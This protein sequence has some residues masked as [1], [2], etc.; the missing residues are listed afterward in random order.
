MWRLTFRAA[1]GSGAAGTGKVGG[2]V[3]AK[4]GEQGTGDGDESSIK[5]SPHGSHTVQYDEV[6]TNK[7]AE[8]QPRSWER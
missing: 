3:R 7:A 1:G 6:A 8:C 5:R 4:H 2:G